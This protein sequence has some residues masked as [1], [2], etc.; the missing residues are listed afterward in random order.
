MGFD[1]IKGFI[2]HKHTKA[3]IESVLTGEINT[4]TH[5][6]GLPGTY[7]V[8]PKEFTLT[9]QDITNGYYICQNFLA[10]NVMIPIFL[11]VD[12]MKMKRFGEHP[13]H[14][15]EQCDYG[16]YTTIDGLFQIKWQA[17]YKL[18]GILRVG[19]VLSLH[20]GLINQ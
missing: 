20:V 18:D 4:H 17:P 15:L 13:D 16:S 5:P 3:Q 9:E 2:L 12:G 10:S 11:F 6:A 7:R 8:Y 1:K 19:D 14:T